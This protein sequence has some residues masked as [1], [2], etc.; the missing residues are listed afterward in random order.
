MTGSDSMYKIIN[1]EKFL[2]ENINLDGKQVLEGGTSWGN[3]TR[4]I[5]ERVK[6]NKWKTKLISVDVDDSHFDEIEKDIG[7]DF[8]E[9]KLRKGDLSDVHFVETET[10]DVVVCNYTL[11]SVNQFPL[12]AVRALKELYRVLKPKGQLL[13][14]EEMPIWSVD[15]SEYEYWSKRLRVIKSISNLKAM[16]Q[17]NEMHP[18]DLESTLE[19]IGFKEIQW[20]EF[21]E[22]INA[23]MATK[24]LDKRKQTLI[25][26]KNDIN[27]KK[28]TD[29]YVEVT[30][31]LV[32]EFENAKEFPAPG[33]IIKAIK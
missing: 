19:I 4:I 25:K 12:R 17:F 32:K 14:T 22:K 13:I 9:L 30:E 28:L 23:E 3:T 21:K 2:W 10:I 1:A 20:R 33:Y 16:A 6:E 31:A 11:S 27:N 5:A 8:R 26:G 24:F 29:G 7:S 18:T 15:N